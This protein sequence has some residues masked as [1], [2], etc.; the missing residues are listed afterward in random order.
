MPARSLMPLAPPFSRAV[1]V[2][3]R[4]SAAVGSSSILPQ[5]PLYRKTAETGVVEPCRT[6]VNVLE[7]TVD[8]S[9]LPGRVAVT[10]ADTETFAAPAEGEMAVTVGAAVSISQIRIAGVAS[11]SPAVSLA[12]TRKVW[13]PVA[14]PLYALGEVQTA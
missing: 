8:M 7:L 11:M 12:R 10:L 1:Y 13:Y 4:C 2:V 6:R 9:S 5:E 3:P 14:S